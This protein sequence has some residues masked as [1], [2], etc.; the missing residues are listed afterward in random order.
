MMATTTSTEDTGLLDSLAPKFKQDTGIE[1]KW[2]STGTGKALKMGENCDVD[3]LWFMLL[4]LKKKKKK[5]AG[6]GKDRKEVMYNDFVIV[7]SKKIQLKLKEKLLKKHLKQL[8]RNK[9]TFISRGDKSGT[10]QK[11]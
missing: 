5:E 4:K 1:L 3:V 9:Q 2:V 10:H 8:K 11:S 6:F 7:G